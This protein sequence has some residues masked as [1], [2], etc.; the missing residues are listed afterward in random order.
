MAL[1]RLLQPHRNPK[2]SGLPAA[3]WPAKRNDLAIIH[4]EV[5]ISQNIDRFLTRTAEGLPNVM[6]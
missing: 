6:K 5:E 4:R 1:R 3:A 2:R